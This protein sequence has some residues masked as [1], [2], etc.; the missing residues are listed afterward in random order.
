MKAGWR[1]VVWVVPAVIAASGCGLH[2]KPPVERRVGSGS[3]PGARGEAGREASPPGP[4]TVVAPGIVE[5]R[6][7][8]IAL[9]AQEPGWIARIEV[10]E[11]ARVEAGQVLA[12]LE[13]ATQR[14]AL[15]LAEA[16]LATA[17]AE[18]ARMVAGATAEELAQARAELAG[19]AAR[20]QL[21]RSSA[22]RA[23]ALHALAVIPDAEEERAVVEERA[24]QAKVD[25]SAAR[26]RE[27]ERGARAEDR[28]AMRARVAAGRA[29]VGMARAA[30]A[31]RVVVAPAAGEILLSRFHPGEHHD[32]G[33]GPLFLLGETARLR[34]R[35]EVDEIDAQDVRAGARCAL[36]S[37]AGAP[38]GEGMVERV[39][40]RMGRRKLSLES[41]TARADVRVREAFVD[42]VGATA[43]VPGQR[44]W[45]R[46]PRATALQGA[47][48]DA[49]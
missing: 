19:A 21:T 13:D 24:Q 35:L 38:V 45:G 16:D 32:P 20:S 5:P 25:R 29:R 26:L 31:R 41:P 23:R 28:E 17:E 22:V 43:L 1:V 10:A 11:G 4:A 9:A 37:D 30:L 34:V 6:G 18:L 49:R 44:V 47:R 46:A 27:L 3:A 7:G 48:A 39:A 14:N 42:V 33:A 36:V 2:D 15:A 40:P 12:T 8:E